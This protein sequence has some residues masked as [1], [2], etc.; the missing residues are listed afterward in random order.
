M[1]AVRK[2]HFSLLYMAF[3]FP[4]PIFQS[5]MENLD[6]FRLELASI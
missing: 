6:S 3:V 1:F 2:Y 5:T 4:I